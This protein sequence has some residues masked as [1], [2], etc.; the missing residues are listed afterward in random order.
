MPGTD[1]RW[2]LV[3]LDFWTSGRHIDLRRAPCQR[4]ARPFAA[5]VAGSMASHTPVLLRTARVPP[6]MD[7][8]GRRRADGAAFCEGG[9]PS[10]Q[11]VMRLASGETPPSPPP[12]LWLGQSVRVPPAPRGGRVSQAGWGAARRAASATRAWGG[13]CGVPGQPG[14][15]IGADCATSV[16]APGLDGFPSWAHPTE[17]YSCMTTQ[18]LMQQR[19]RAAVRRR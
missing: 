2:R 3:S 9:A 17:A 19:E 5:A 18:R 16:V 6:G 15:R 14:G 10:G 1:G 7:L 11:V 8:S 4:A 12:S 13:G